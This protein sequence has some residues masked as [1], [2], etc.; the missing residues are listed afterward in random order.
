MDSLSPDGRARQFGR[1]IDCSLRFPRHG[2][3]DAVHDLP[4]QVAPQVAS[5]Q[6]WLPREWH[7]DPI[8]HGRHSNDR[9]LLRVYDRHSRCSRYFRRC[10]VA[11]TMILPIH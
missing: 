1:R 3:V 4:C 11:D 9:L 6:N 7:T 10:V 2:W 5:P 8:G